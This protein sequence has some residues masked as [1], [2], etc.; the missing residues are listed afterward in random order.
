[1]IFAIDVER[2]IALINADGS[3]AR[4]EES[5]R[6]QVTPKWVWFVVPFHDNDI[7]SMPLQSMD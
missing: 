1:M 7:T 6:W 3:T 2:T 4:P 5:A